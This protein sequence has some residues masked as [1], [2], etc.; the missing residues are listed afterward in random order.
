MTIDTVSSAL[1]MGAMRGR[2]DQQRQPVAQPRIGQ[3]LNLQVGRDLG[4]GRYLVSFGDAQRV[5]KSTV[6]LTTGSTLRA[7][8]TGVGEKL[9]LRYEDEQIG[10]EFIENEP[11]GNDSLAQLEARYAVS[12]RDADRQAIE[13]AMSAAANSTTMAGGGLYLGKL[14][15]PIDAGALDALYAAQVWDAEGAHL[16]RAEAQLGLDAGEL[17]S[18]TSISQLAAWMGNALD[19]AAGG[20]ISGAVAQQ[21]S[22]GQLRDSSRDR[23]DDRRNLARRLLNVQDEGSL[24]YQYGVLPV[25]IA[26]QLV[27]LD[28]VHFRERRD[29]DQPAGLRRLVMTLKTPTLGRIEIQAQAVGDRLSLGI[30]AESAQ[31]SDALAAHAE[32]VR[33]LISRLGWN[34]GTISYDFNADR[35]R[36][37]RHIVEHVL[38]AGTL[39]RLA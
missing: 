11:S 35:G 31:S 33:E 2:A 37:A 6:P 20:Q 25:L 8:V 38:N 28:L 9:E 12:L 18:G 1:M 3:S 16:S 10:G 7:T 24:A 21:V 4:G 19:A 39:S 22:V 36:A 13:A 26:D 27:E 34:V 30:K 14:A 15:L 5:V 17:P 29:A 32:E 23:S